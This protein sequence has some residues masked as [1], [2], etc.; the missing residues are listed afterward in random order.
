MGNVQYTAVD[1]RPYLQ[2]VKNQGMCGSCWAFGTIA[3]IEGSYAAY[4]RVKLPY[5]LS[6]QQLVDCDTGDS[7]CNG[8]WFTNAILY[9]V[10]NLPMKDIDYPYKALQGTCKYDKTKGVSDIRPLSYKYS[11]SPDTNFASLKIGP[12]AAAIDANDSFR[13]YTSGVWNAACG[14]AV[15]HAVF[16]VGYSA[17]LT[18]W[19]VQ[20]SWAS[21]WGEKGFIMVADQGANNKYSCYI[22]RY[23]YRAN[24]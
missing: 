24:Y 18:A 15:N 2:P 17:T 1:W 10:A 13:K 3:M 21:T 14:T 5:A 20:N 22:G 6:T 4:K 8:G 7:G 9:L 19:I 23:G 12:F 16:V 11:S